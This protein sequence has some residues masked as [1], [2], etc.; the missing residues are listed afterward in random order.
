LG[1][2]LAKEPVQ[3]ERLRNETDKID[4]AEHRRRSQAMSDIR[5]KG[6]PVSQKQCRDLG[7]AVFAF[8]APPESTILTTNLRDLR[9]LAETL[10]KA[11]KSPNEVVAEQT[12]T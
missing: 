7:D 2:E 1:D 11:C 8:F 6:P 12:K 9:P 10:G 3:L 4:N 5:R